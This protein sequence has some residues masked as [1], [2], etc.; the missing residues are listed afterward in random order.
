M[1]DQQSLIFPQTASN[2]QFARSA[3]DLTWERTD[4]ADSLG[5]AAGVRTA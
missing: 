2:A 5:A 3:P 1:L 4:K